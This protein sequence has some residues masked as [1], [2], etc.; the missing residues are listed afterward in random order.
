MKKGILISLLLSIAFSCN[1]I[2]TGETLS[3]PDIKYIKSLHLLDDNEEIYKFYSEFKMKNAGNFFT[4][5][6]IATYWIDPRNDKKNKISYAFYKEIK[7][8]D[9]VYNAGV[10]YS[11]YLLVTKR[12]GD[13]FKVYVNGEKDEIKSFFEEAIN[14]WHKNE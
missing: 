14:T 3:Q 10:T 1:K 4:N 12:N 9:T 6:R 11:P 7:S 13:S 2:V 5:M 8:I